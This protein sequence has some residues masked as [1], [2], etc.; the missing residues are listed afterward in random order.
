MKLQ[1]YHVKFRPVDPVEGWE[2]LAGWP[3]CLRGHLSSSCPPP[4]APTHPS[5]PSEAACGPHR[6]L[7]LLCLFPEG[8]DGK[9]RG[10]RRSLLLGGLLEVG[11][12][13]PGRPS[14]PPRPQAEYPQLVTHKTSILKHLSRK[15]LQ[16]GHG[17]LC[18]YLV[19]FAL[20]GSSS[21]LPFSSFS[22]TRRLSLPPA[23]T[24]AAAVGRGGREK[25]GPLHRQHLLWE[26]PSVPQGAGAGVERSCGHW[27]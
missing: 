2:G 18:G 16:L 20:G 3:T 17:H 19:V 14:P 5:L 22:V 1:R 7:G 21:V 27:L 8:S 24:C 6:H 9:G 23:H 10:S 13:A 15:R 4:S 12:E 26:E 25:E 11:V